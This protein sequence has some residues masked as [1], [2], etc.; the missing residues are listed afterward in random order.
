MV[1][2]WGPCAKINRRTALCLIQ[3]PSAIVVVVV[4]VFF[5]SNQTR[6]DDDDDGRR[7]RRCLL[8]CGLDGGRAVMQV[9]GDG[10]GGGGAGR[11]GCV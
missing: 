2:V 9:D 7:R 8:P 1:P 10:R 11:S 4:L 6:R 5:F 3:W